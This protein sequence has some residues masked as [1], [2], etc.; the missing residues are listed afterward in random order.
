M[1][2]ITSH[3]HPFHMEITPCMLGNLILLLVQKPTEYFRN[4]V[5]LETLLRWELCNKELC[6]W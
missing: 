2:Q 6:H 3:T 5:N 4:L 1:L